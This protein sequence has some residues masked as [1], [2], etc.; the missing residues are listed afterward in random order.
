MAC[1]ARQSPSLPAPT[2]WRGHGLVA[3]IMLLAIA[4]AL[5]GNAW[6]AAGDPAGRVG[7]LSLAN[8][9]VDATADPAADWAAASLNM[10]VSSGTT[11]RTGLQSRAEWRVGSVSLQMNVNSQLQVQTLDDQSLVVLLQYGNLA[12]HLRTL[13]SGEPPGVLRR[14]ARMLTRP[15]GM[16]RSIAVDFAAA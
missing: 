16:A 2:R 15:A 6:A 9:S 7:R 3:T 4:C 12:L 1:P 14:P 8:G 5:C 10:P 11:L 13:G